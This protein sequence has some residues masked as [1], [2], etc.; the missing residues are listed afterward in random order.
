MAVP[1]LHLPSRQAQSLLWLAELS[2]DQFTALDR[3]VTHAQAQKP[4]PVLVRDFA[5]ARGYRPDQGGRAANTLVSLKQFARQGEHSSS[6]I[7]TAVELDPEFEEQSE[8]RKI[9]A[10]R[11]RTA[12]SWRTL[13]DYER[14]SDLLGASQNLLWDSRILTDLRPL[15]SSEEEA[16]IEAGLVV[17]TL[18][19]TYWDGSRV[20][21]FY[22]AM[23]RDE[24][25]GLQ[26]AVRRAL[27]KD[28]SIE[29]FM[30]DAKLPRVGIEG[31]EE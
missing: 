22:V 28:A 30:T 21:N 8:A 27:N 26:R 20:S 25:R 9:L 7:A 16:D 6:E 29:K 4:F 31:D 14:A 2:D 17:H 13:Q 12:L 24:L 10:D 11:V 19:L 15:F 1:D 23:D 3:A 18:E 5:E